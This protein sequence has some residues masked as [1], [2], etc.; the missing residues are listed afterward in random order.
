MRIHAPKATILAI[1]VASSTLLS[2][3]AVQLEKTRKIAMASARLSVSSLPLIAKVTA[4]YGS[5]YAVLISAFAEALVPGYEPPEDLG[6]GDEDED[7]DDDDYD[8]EDYDDEDYEDDAD[9]EDDEYDEDYNDTDDYF[10]DMELFDGEYD[11]GEAP[12]EVQI[13]VLQ[14]VIAGQRSKGIPIRNGDVLTEND[15]YKVQMSCSVDCYAYIAQLDS[16]GRLDPVVPSELVDLRNPLEADITYSAPNGNNWFYLDASKGVEQIYFIFSLT[17]RKD[18]ELIFSQLNEANKE[19]VAKE[20]ISIEEPMKL[21]RGIAG[22]R[23]GS[24]QQVELSS[25]G[26]SQYVSTVLKSIEADLVL[27]K[28]FR[29][30]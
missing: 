23:S 20:P 26:Q 19:L 27:T 6:R 24:A 28:W 15:N 17:P 9:Y 22:V 30:E 5:S 3:S 21:T 2:C 8:D 16:K 18:I 14:E 1:V 12:L 7:Y 10:G 29:H 11:S 13:N 25:G 4:A